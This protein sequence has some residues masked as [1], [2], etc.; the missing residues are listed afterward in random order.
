MTPVS[1]LAVPPP[2][3][4]AKCMGSDDPDE[5]TS[6]VSRRDGH[7]SR[8]VHGTG[9][10]GFRLARIETLSVQIAWAST[11][12]ANTL[13]ARFRQPTF[14]VPLGGVQRY[15]YGRRR[16]EAAMGRLV[17]I[18]PD[19]EVTR[20]SDGDPVMAIELDGSK[21]ES[22]VRGRRASD[23]I[24]RPRVP[25]SLDLAEAQQR[26]VAEA[27]A[28]LVHAHLPGAAGTARMHGE[29]RVLSALAGTLTGP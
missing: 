11:R 12:L 19:T 27:I 2:P 17:F 25:Q 26:E 7:H 16:V 23:R 1:V 4:G 29:S 9:P 18:A 28:A 14:H 20:H 6:W 3:P 15:A 22:E 13:R 5:I 21:F 8:V 24:E 10:Y